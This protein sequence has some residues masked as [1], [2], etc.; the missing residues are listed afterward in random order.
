MSNPL[1]S[2]SGVVNKR[3][4]SIVEQFRDFM[5]SFKWDPQARI[6]ELLA[7]GKI[8]KSQLNQATELANMIKGMMKK[9]L[10]SYS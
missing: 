4:K 2:I 7:S 10:K 8:T 6:N 9:W 3:P 5:G 1:L